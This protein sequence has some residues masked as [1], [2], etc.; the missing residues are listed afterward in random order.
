MCVCREGGRI[1]R[2]PQADELRTFVPA[3]APPSE[4]ERLEL[5]AAFSA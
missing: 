5:T 2:I 3:A 1:E 4:R